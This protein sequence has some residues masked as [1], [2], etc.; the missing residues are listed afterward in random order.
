MRIIQ[1][2]KKKQTRLVARYHSQDIMSDMRRAEARKKQQKKI[3]S[4]R[5]TIQLLLGKYK[6]KKKKKIEKKKK[7]KAPK[8]IHVNEPYEYCD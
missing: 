2:N 8:D 6:K 3:K 4:M 7:K 1:E 5:R